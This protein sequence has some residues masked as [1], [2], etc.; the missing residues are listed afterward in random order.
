MLFINNLNNKTQTKRLYYMKK[1]LLLTM[2]LSFLF[3]F[4]I[5]ALSYTHWGDYNQVTNTLVS[6]GLSIYHKDSD[7]IYQISLSALSSTAT[8][9]ALKYSFKNTDLGTRPNG[10]KYSFPSGHTTA[11]FTGVYFLHHK[12]GYYYSIPA[13]LLATSVAHSRIK[14]NYH[15]L[16]DCLA[17]ALI[18][19]SF[20]Y[21]YTKKTGWTPLFDEQSKLTGISFNYKF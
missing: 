13:F 16:R 19:M 1:F 14:G 18:A 12:Y 9:L 3:S 4:N 7:G 6:L 15:Y 17:G 10:G 2:P 11:A 21:F 20:D 5:K 8:S